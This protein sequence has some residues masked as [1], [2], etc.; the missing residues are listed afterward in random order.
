MVWI[1]A[2]FP[3]VVIFDIKDAYSHVIIATSNSLRT[4]PMADLFKE[5]FSGKENLYRS[6]SETNTNL[7]NSMAVF[8]RTVLCHIQVDFQ[9]GISLSY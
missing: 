5:A 2:E 6:Q 7:D 9:I 8:F 1:I 4:F 3:L